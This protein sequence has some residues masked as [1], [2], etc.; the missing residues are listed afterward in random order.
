VSHHPLHTQCKK[1]LFTPEGLAR[2]RDKISLR[3]TRDGRDEK[4]VTISA[5]T[6]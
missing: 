5:V 4:G 3:N 1:E 2:K 6:P